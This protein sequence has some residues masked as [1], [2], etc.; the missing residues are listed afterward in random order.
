[1]SKTTY[2]LEAELLPDT[3]QAVFIMYDRQGN[4][5]VL[6]VR[7]AGN[8]MVR[9]LGEWETECAL[10]EAIMLLAEN[11]LRRWFPRFDFPDARL[12]WLEVR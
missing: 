2:R 4:L 11:R 6:S 12:T 8:G 9:V 10:P 3:V 7:Y 5:A 1:M